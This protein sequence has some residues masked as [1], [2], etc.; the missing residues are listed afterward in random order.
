MLDTDLFT[1]S[2]WPIFQTMEISLRN[3]IQWIFSSQV[4]QIQGFKRSIFLSNLS[5][6]VFQ[7]PRIS[8]TSGM[9][10]TEHAPHRLYK[11]V[12]HPLAVLKMHLWSNPKFSW[13][14]NKGCLCKP[15]EKMFAVFS[16]ITG[17]VCWGERRGAAEKWVQPVGTT[18]CLTDASTRPPLKW[19]IYFSANGRF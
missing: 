13:L 17:L 11:H 2:K 4:V 19:V 14:V 1:Q 10:G 3:K 7:E 5:S 16:S 9:H 8:L 12:I 15:S 6:L 18:A